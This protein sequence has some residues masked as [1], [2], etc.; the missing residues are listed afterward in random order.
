MQDYSKF[1]EQTQSYFNSLPIFLKEDI[2][3]SGVQFCS[4]KDMQNL[5]QN[6]TYQKPNS[7]NRER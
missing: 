4:K 7:Q 6:L 2:M 5:V 3:Q 1:N